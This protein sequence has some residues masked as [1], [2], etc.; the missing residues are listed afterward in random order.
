MIRHVVMWKL[1]E[2]AQGA[3]KHENAQKIKTMLE[4]LRWDIP[5][6]LRLEVGL[7]MLRAPD[8]FDV[9]LVSEFEDPEALETYLNHPQHK[10]VGEFVH[11]VKIEKK[12]VDYHI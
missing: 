5:E 6:I 2:C 11:S 8:S 4:S 10:K 7:D 3:D 1:K 12:V 9:V